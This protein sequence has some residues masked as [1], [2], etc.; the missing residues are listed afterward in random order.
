LLRE[1]VRGERPIDISVLL[2]KVPQSG[3][4]DRMA[5]LFGPPKGSEREKGLAPL[6]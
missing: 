3:G 6:H 1:R 5:P 4:I 2:E